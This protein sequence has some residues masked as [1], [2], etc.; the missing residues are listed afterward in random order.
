MKCNS[1]TGTPEGRLVRE[2][3]FSMSYVRVVSSPSSCMLPWPPPW[4]EPDF[5]Y[6]IPISP[7]WEAGMPPDM[8][9]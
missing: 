7:E 6:I 4:E 9:W 1:F 5:M 2:G 3:D 8:P